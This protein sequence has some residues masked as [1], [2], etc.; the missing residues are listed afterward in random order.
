MIGDVCGRGVDAAGATALVRHT[1]RAEARHCTG[2]REVMRAVHE[3]MED[4]PDDERFCTAVYGE[5]K[6]VD[7]RVKVEVVSAGHPEP[8]LVRAD[9]SVE[10]VPTA[11]SVLGLFPID[12]FAVEQIELGRGD[13][14]VLFTDGV[15]EA[16]PPRADDGP[17][18][19]F[20]DAD[21]VDA[22]LRANAAASA[23]TMANALLAAVIDYAG[24]RV[25]DDIAILVLRVP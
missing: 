18:D 11:T 6:E 22:L 13:S 3:A 21:R 9:G 4:S 25:F 5:F 12:D 2:P 15:L 17:H 19:F 24:G 7:G 16:R 20:G 1:A 10:T 8:R 23:A 14:L